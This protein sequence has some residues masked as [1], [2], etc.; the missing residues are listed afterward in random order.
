MYNRQKLLLIVAVLIDKIN[1]S[2]LSRNIL[3][4][5]DQF[6]FNN[7]QTDTSSNWPTAD[8]VWYFAAT[9]LSLLQQLYTVDNEF[10]Y[11]ATVNVFLLQNQIINILPDKGFK[12][13][14]LSD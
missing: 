13:L 7:W 2:L 10:F 4:A 3:T 8:H 11:M 9:S 5:L 6:W 12:R 14:F 1:V